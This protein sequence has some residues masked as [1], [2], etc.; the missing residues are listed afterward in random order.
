MDFG[1]V[2][3]V[4]TYDSGGSQIEVTVEFLVNRYVIY[5]FMECLKP[6]VPGVLMEPIKAILEH[7]PKGV[8]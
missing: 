4:R 5:E 2:E 7:S 6:V 3:Q 8:E 1:S